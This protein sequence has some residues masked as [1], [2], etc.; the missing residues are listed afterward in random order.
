MHG[1]QLLLKLR[2]QVELAYCQHLSV[3]FEQLRKARTT[4]GV[5][6]CDCMKKASLITS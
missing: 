5:H 1:P 4:R 6:G 3:S 2:E